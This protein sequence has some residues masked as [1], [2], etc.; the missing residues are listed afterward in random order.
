MKILRIYQDVIRDKFQY[1]LIEYTQSLLITKRSVLKLFAKIF[2]PIG[3]LT[4]FAINM[5]I[6]FQILCI[7]KVTWDESL[8]GEVLVK[9]KSFINNLNT[10]KNIRVPRC[11]ANHPMT[12]SVMCSYQIHG[13]SYASKRVYT[14]VVYLRTEVSN[15]EIQVN[16]VTL[17]TSAA[18][19]K[20]QS[21]P[22]LELLGATLLG[23]L[24]HLT[25]QV[26]QSILQIEGTFLWADSFTTLC[27]IK[28]G[29]AWKP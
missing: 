11:Y 29:K 24:V 23:Q 19:I 17:K 20:P 5:R 14:A 10:L 18:L 13:F 12:E 15:G 7:K 6:L 28:N 21:I 2:D 22:R 9:L 8:E 26:L 3:L 16:I 1:E 4:P 27:W 25:Q